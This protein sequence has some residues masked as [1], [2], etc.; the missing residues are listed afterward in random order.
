MRRL[1]SLR[2]TCFG[3]QSNDP[4]Q[5]RKGKESLVSPKDFR[6]ISL[7]NRVENQAGERDGAVNGTH[8]SSQRRESPAA[9]GVL[10]FRKNNKNG[11]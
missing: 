4:T 3:K 5:V 2:W 10:G 1:R 8:L 6:N 11:A 9:Q 7:K